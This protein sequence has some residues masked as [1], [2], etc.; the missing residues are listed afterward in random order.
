[1]YASY[2]VLSLIE[3]NTHKIRN[4]YLLNLI[5]FRNINQLF[6]IVSIH[7]VLK[8]K[9]WN[10][11]C[12]Y[13]MLSCFV[14]YRGNFS[15]AF[16]I[17]TTKDCD[18]HSFS[19]LLFK[20]LQFKDINLVYFHFYLL[21]STGI[22]RIHKVTSWRRVNPRNVCLVN[23]FLPFILA[24]LGTCNWFLKTSSFA[25]ISLHILERREIITFSKGISHNLHLFSF[26]K[27][28]GLIN[29]ERYRG[30]HT[31]RS[32]RMVDTLKGWMLGPNSI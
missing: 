27:M 10:N 18:V 21:T 17:H 11:K 29:N 9:V 19:N 25:K 12:I 32:R 4:S 2:R 24:R 15:P 16:C 22:V 30:S 5:V 20:N 6:S 28:Y 23:S 3:I 8:K 1:M 26:L 7:F 31:G 13:H 14:H